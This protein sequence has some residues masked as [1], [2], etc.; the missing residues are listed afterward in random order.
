MRAFRGAMMVLAFAVV[1]CGGGGDKAT[2]TTTPPPGGGGG[3]GGGTGGS[4]SN[5][6]TVDD[7]FFDPASTTLA[8]NT[9]VTWTWHGGQAHN[10][11]FANSSL[12]G[13][14]DKTTGTFAKTFP[15]AGTFNYQCTLHPGMNGVIIIQ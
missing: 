4:T 9:T 10:V 11:T 6:V 2:G 8:T 12:S 14:G 1:S 13:S 3:G 7:N 5:S 15:S